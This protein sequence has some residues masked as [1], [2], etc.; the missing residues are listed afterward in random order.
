MYFKPLLIPLL[1]QVVLTFVVMLVMFVKRV[2]EMKSKNILPQQVQTR[3]SL[4]GVLTESENPTSNY[5]NLFESPI[6]FYVA[7]L[8]TLNLMLQD[9]ILVVLCWCYVG[10]RYVH[11]FIHVTYNDVMHRFYAFLFST[12]MLLAI[13]VRLG[14]VILQP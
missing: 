1:A 12:F 9:T 5:A 10:A 4:H 13:W 2:N 8:L 11:S 14:G 7:I 3:S 6:L